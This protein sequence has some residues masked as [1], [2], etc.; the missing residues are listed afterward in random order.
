[1]GFA[2]GLG[3]TSSFLKNLEKRFDDFFSD[4]SDSFSFSFPLLDE[5]AIESE[6]TDFSLSEL[7]DFFELR[8]ERA[9]L[10]IL[11]TPDFI[12]DVSDFSGI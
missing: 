5:D 12:L 6:E 4:D 10:R 8:L 11:D 2:L 9:V 3:G 7:P 1:V